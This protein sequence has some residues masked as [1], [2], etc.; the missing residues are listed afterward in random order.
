MGAL[1]ASIDIISMCSLT[2][3]RKKSQ[4]LCEL[5]IGLLAEKNSDLNL[6]SPRQTDLRGAHIAFMHFDAYAI[7]RAL[8]AAGIVCDFRAPNLIR[9]GLAPLYIRYIDVFNTVSLLARILNEES[10]RAPQFQQKV[11]VT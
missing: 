6:V 2:D 10:Y 8:S 5:F 9:F 11:T 3:I 4:Q 1:D 7:S